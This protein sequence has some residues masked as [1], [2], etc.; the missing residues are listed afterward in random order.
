[1]QLLPLPWDKKTKSRSK[2]PRPTAEVRHK[3]FEEM[4]HRLGNEINQ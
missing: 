3:R 4:A 1:M 2:A